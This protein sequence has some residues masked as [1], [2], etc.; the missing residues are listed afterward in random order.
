MINLAVK[1]LSEIDNISL[2]DDIKDQLTNQVLE[3]VGIEK[4]KTRKYTPG[5]QEKILESLRRLGGSAIRAE[6][7]SDSGLDPNVVSS[8]LNKLVKS[9]KVKKVKLDSNNSSSTRSGRG[10]DPEYIYK[11]VGG[12]NGKVKTAEME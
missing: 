1:T 5:S 9:K 11:L 8:M 3:V 10:L 12:E 6:L 7:A 4:T 2:G